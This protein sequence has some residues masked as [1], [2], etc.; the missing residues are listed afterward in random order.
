M[1]FYK[2]PF[3]RCEVD[4]DDN[5]VILP[6]TNLI[7]PSSNGKVVINYPWYNWEA[8]GF[9]GK[10]V[11][12]WNHLR[13]KVWAF[14]RTD[15]FPVNN[16]DYSRKALWQIRSIVDYTLENSEDVAGVPK[17]DLEIYLMW[18]SAWAWAMAAISSFYAQVSKILLMA[19]A[20]WNVWAWPIQEWLSQYTWECYIATWEDDDVVWRNAWDYFSEVA[21]NASLVENVTIPDCD[22]QFRWERNGK[23]M[24]S[25][26]LRAFDSQLPFIV[27]ENKWIKL[28]D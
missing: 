15:N 13:D 16:I 2:A 23:I 6:V 11:T 28:Y 10:Y 19:P 18:F 14:V 9:V 21:Q 25:L 8:D 17:D 12:L 20:W 24:S 7:H 27:T 5:K 3:H 4:N 1:W 22:H 26:T